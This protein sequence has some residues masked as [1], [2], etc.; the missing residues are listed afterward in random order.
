MRIRDRLIGGTA[1]NLIA[2][3]FN[4]G[5]TL[6]INII[7]ARILMKQAFGEYTMVQS[8]LLTMTTLSQLS[9]GYTASKY[10]AEYRS[11]FPEKAERIMGLCVVVT[12]LMAVVAAFLLV[13]VAPWLAGTML[14]APPLTGPLQIGAGFLFFSTING[15]QTGA[16]AGLEAY[17]G[18]AKAGVFSGL[19][20]LPA[21]SIATYVG[22]ING[23]LTGLSISALLRCGIHFW[24]LHLESQKQGIKPNYRELNKEKSVILNFALPSSIAGWYA[25][26]MI[27]LG[28]SFLVRQ[29]G[30]YS[31]MAMY[32]AATN[33]KSLVLFLPFVING[34]V[35]SILNHVKGSGN[36]KQ[37]EHLYHFN[38]LFVFLTS[39]T[40]ALFLGYFGDITLG[41]FGKSFMAAKQVLL[42]LLLSSVFE[43][44]T[45]SL[46]QS[47]QNHARMWLS[48]L[49]INLP[50]GPVF[51][52]LAYML[53]PKHGAIG[54]GVANVSM[55]ALSLLG[56][57]IMAHY[58]NK[59]R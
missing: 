6:M 15:Y 53:I 32:S 3:A 30:G 27:W 38:I 37:Y 2:V 43:A 4:Q 45:S 40:L 12:A 47:I 11:V 33:I 51:V 23:A 19:T 44:T 21:I 29:D 42:I 41:I 25:M 52:I 48:F 54:L 8:T 59:H 26:P 49:S 18:L 36:R 46:Y 14:K 10:I 7:V 28:N 31:E 5:S 57:G 24:W 22:G 50:L 9:T 16:L 58:I 35:S 1:M 55:A 20:A 39:S 56:T 17:G 13:A 34:V